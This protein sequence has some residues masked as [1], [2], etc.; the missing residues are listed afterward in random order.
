[1]ANIDFHAVLETLKVGAVSLATKTVQNYVNDAKADGLKLVESLKTDIQIWVQ[2]LEAGK[3]S[4]AD[5]EFLVMAKKD[6]IEMNALKQAGL[7]LIKVDE[8]KNSLLQL[9]VKTLVS[10]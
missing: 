4:A 8:F 7:G 9:I 10:L 6:V 2:E 1:M 5:V 3:L